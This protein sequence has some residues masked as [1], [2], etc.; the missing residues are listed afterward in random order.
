[1]W[2]LTCLASGSRICSWNGDIAPCK[3]VL[4]V[5]SLNQTLY[6]SWKNLP[7]GSSCSV[8]VARCA[9]A[10]NRSCSQKYRLF[11]KVRIRPTCNSIHTWHHWWWRSMKFSGKYATV[12]D[13]LATNIPG[14]PQAKWIFFGS[15]A[16]RS[17]RPG[18][19]QRYTGSPFCSRHVNIASKW[20]SFWSWQSSARFLR[21]RIWVDRIPDTEMKWW[22][23][24]NVR[25]N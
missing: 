24:R 11:C 14:Q 2:S 21:R 20:S 1:M 6:F 25:N 9:K 16:H 19:Y 4:N 3:K 7:I 15:E 17:A 13:T 12:P 22:K 18:E 8:L 10:A 23:L 5:K